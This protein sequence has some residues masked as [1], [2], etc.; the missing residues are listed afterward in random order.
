MASEIWLNCSVLGPDVGNVFPVDILP[1][2]GVGHL[3]DAIK[4]KKAPKLDHLAAD[5]LGIY[6]VSDFAQYTHRRRCVAT[7]F[8]LL[9]PL[10]R[11]KIVPILG[12][13]VNGANTPDAVELDSMKKLSYYFPKDPVAEALHLVIQVPL[14]GESFPIRDRH[15]ITNSTSL[16]LFRLVNSIIHQLEEAL[17]SCNR[18]PRKENAK[19]FR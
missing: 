11:D 2:K 19:R 7:H 9:K 12:T 5:E 6:K 8:Q 3:K 18:N 16:Q 4:N 13:I 1:S 17:I 14:S 15:E 10:S